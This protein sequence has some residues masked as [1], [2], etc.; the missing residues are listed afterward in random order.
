MI[1][2]PD[3]TH[4]FGAGSD[5]DMVTDDGRAFAASS[6]RLSN[7]HAL[8]NVAILPDDGM[9]VDHDIADMADVAAPADRG[10]VRNQATK[11]ILV[12]GKYPHRDPVQRPKN[13]SRPRRL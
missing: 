13:R 11:L 5:I 4:D 7:L 8:A 1:A 10:R 9:F 3:R 2:H 6:I 12:S